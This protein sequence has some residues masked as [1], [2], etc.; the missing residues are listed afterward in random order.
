MM[1]A[2]RVENKCLAESDQPV[3]ASAETDKSYEQIVMEAPLET[4]TDL[5]Q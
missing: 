1:R 3:G 4:H 2:Q 5:P